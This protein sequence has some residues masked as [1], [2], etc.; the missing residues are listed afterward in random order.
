[1]ELD[2]HPYRNLFAVSDR[3]VIVFVP[4]EHGNEFPALQPPL[5]QPPEPPSDGL[6]L[7]AP[8][9]DSGRCDARLRGVQ[10]QGSQGRLIGLQVTQ[11]CFL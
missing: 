10:L 6:R 3:F 2:E 5:E 11:N 1:M 9:R 4:A 8:K 7:A